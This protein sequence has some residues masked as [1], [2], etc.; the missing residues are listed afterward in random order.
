M[1]DTSDVL[2]TYCACQES[3][4]HQ[5][6]KQIIYIIANLHAQHCS[7]DAV[8]WIMQHGPMWHAIWV[9]I[10]HCANVG[11]PVASCIVTHGLFLA[12]S[13][14]FRA[15]LSS[16]SLLCDYDGGI[17]TLISSKS[18]VKVA[19]RGM[20]PCFPGACRVGATEPPLSPKPS[21]GGTVT[22]RLPPEPSHRTG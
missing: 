3:M 10:L 6:R 14:Y 12:C 8:D 13:I 15:Q 21:A 2:F 7:T 22:V 17:D 1:C 11:K 19:S 4:L 18:Y 5:R 20:T 16:N 9:I